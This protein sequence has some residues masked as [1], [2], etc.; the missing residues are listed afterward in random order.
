MLELKD[1]KK[2]HEFDINQFKKAIN[3]E[4]CKYCNFK[5]LCRNEKVKYQVNLMKFV[6][7]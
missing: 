7:E 6:N 2:F 5:S 1:D 4:S 3:S